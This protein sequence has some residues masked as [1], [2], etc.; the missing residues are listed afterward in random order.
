ME[1]GRH[2]R[3]EKDTITVTF[4]PDALAALEDFY[5]EVEPELGPDGKF[6]DMAEWGNKVHGQVARIA[7][8]LH[9]AEAGLDGLRQPVTLLAVERAIRIGRYLIDQ[10]L[11]AHDLMGAVPGLQLAKEALRIIRKQ[12]LT[13][14]KPR[15]LQLAR[16]AVFPEAET[17]RQA[18]QVL[19][20]H[21]WL[22]KVS[23]LRGKRWE[24]NP[25]T[26]DLSSVSS[27]SSVCRD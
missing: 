10:A 1:L 2:V 22:R 4:A 19:E 7:V 16:R 24:V 15:D 25:A 27:V 18:L 9:I 13:E 14:V 23:D 3:S 6:A 17:A 8:L 12:G 21:D 11:A 20:D 5:G 26:H